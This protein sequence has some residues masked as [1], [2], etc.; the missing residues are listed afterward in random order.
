MRGRWRSSSGIS[1]KIKNVQNPIKL[2]PINS[3]CFIHQE[4]NNSSCKNI[5]IHTDRRN[6]KSTS[7][8][9][10]HGSLWIWNQITPFLFQNY[11]QS[12]NYTIGITNWRIKEVEKPTS[13]W[14]SM[15]SRASKAWQCSDLFQ[16][17]PWDGWWWNGSLT[18]HE[19]NWISN[20]HECFTLWTWTLQ[21][22]FLLNSC[23]NVLNNTS[24]WWIKQEKVFLFEGHHKKN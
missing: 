4:S 7:K 15:K 12:M 16:Y 2:I 18:M 17:A 3:P 9:K 14:T 10:T 1:R 19:T 13:W 6:Q 8:L 23:P 20:C 24:W 22:R 11:H 21:P 5:N